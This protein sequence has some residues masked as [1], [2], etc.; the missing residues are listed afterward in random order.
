M[1]Q[2]MSTEKIGK[3]D[4]VVFAVAGVVVFRITDTG[5]DDIKII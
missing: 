3:A 5:T 4:K 1:M 2:W